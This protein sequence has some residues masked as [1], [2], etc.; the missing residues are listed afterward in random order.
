M[1]NDNNSQN[2]SGGGSWVDRLTERSLGDIRIHDSAQ[3]GELARRLGARAF[4]VGRDIY[5]RPELVNSKTPEG[6][7][8]LAHEVTHA[9]EQSGASVSDMPLLRPH[10]HRDASP[11]PSGSSGGGMAVQRASASGGSAPASLPSSEVTAEAVESST[12][13]SA[14]A[15]QSGGGGGAQNQEKSNTQSSSQPNA[16][17]VAERVYALMVKEMIIDIE[18]SA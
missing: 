11:G 15:P 17:E 18:R 14:S 10:L 16:D 5:V 13:Q 12:L 7:A 3:A 9:V 2:E 4:T 1:D 6:E 8:L